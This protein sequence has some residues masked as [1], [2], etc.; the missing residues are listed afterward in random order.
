MFK[1]RDT[2]AQPIADTPAKL[3]DYVSK[4]KDKLTLPYK[5]RNEQH[6]ESNFNLYR[7]SIAS[8]MYLYNFLMNRVPSDIYRIKNPKLE[9]GSE[10]RG[11]NS[12]VFTV[13]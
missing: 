11:G 8:Y 4:V 1:L 7:S 12:R 13:R 2:N 6:L 5:D 9:I 10:I 3:I